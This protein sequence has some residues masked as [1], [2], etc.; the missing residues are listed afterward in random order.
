MYAL[1]GLCAVCAAY[2]L[3]RAL[4]TQPA[5]GIGCWWMVYVVAAVG[6][7]Y[8]HNLGAFALLG[9][10]VLALARGT[11]RRRFLSLA[12]ADCAVLVLFAPWLIGVLPGQIGFVGRG[13]WLSEPGIEELVRALMLP[14]LT[15]YEPAPVWVLGVGLF[16]G[17]L[18]LVLSIL[19]SV[20]MRGRGWWFLIAAWVPVGA[21]FAVSQW[22]PVYLERALLPSALFYLLTLAW[23]L[24]D[25]RLPRAIRALVGVLLIV[26]YSGSLVQHFTY[27]GFPRPRF[28]QAVAFLEAE[29]QPGDRV[30]HTNKLTYFPMLVYGPQLDGVF[31][32]DPAGAPQDTL[33]YPT[34]EALGI[35]ATQTLDEAL[36]S[37]TRVWLITF[38]REIAEVERSSGNHYV[39]EHIQADYQLVDE[40]HFDDLIIGHYVW[41]GG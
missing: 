23:L 1:L 26:G 37:A 3:L 27:F 5:R 9:L 40:W 18:V 33:A 11:W 7:L 22:R 4:E 6:T 21:L 17:L 32:A 41:H 36:E 12:L 10:N 24:M 28:E 39:L 29:I 20:R 31:L 25:A 30:V 8:A 38:E 16:A 35:F 2:G 14:V 34:Q 13:Y 19:R 15:F